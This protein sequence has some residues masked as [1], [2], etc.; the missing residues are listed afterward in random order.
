MKSYITLRVTK[1]VTG[2]DSGIESSDSGGQS[3][4]RY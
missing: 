3:L 2:V 1:S 4:Y